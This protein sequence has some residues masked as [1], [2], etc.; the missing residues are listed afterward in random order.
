MLLDAPVERDLGWS[1]GAGYYDLDVTALNKHGI[2][3]S[4]LVLQLGV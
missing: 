4:P 1:L 3:N 2:T